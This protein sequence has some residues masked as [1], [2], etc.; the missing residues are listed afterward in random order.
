MVELTIAVDQLT[1]LE[2]VTL[3]LIDYS[4]ACPS[5]QR[6]FLKNYPDR[7]WHKSEFTVSHT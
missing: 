4:L 5:W 6:V 7:Q 1:Q 3:D 2:A